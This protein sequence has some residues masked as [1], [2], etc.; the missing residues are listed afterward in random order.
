MNKLLNISL[1]ALAAIVFA[2][3]A[4]EE[5]DL[6][7]SS[8]AERLAA[9]KATYTER[10]AADGGTWVM[11]YFPTSYTY[12]PQGL[13]YLLLMT[14]S[15]DGS[16]RVAMKNDFSDGDYK[17]DTSL[18]EVIADTGP[19]LSFNTY[20]ECLHAF[21]DPSDLSFTTDDETGLGA[22]GDYEFIILNLE[23]G[24]TEATLKGKKRSVYERLRKLPADTDFEAYIE[25][26]EAF[27]D[28]IFSSSAPNYALLTVGDSVKRIDDGYSTIPNIYRL[29]GDAVVNESYHPFIISMQDSIY[30]LRFRDEFEIGE[31]VV[32][33]FTYDADDEMFHEVDNSAYTISGPNPTFFMEGERWNFTRT[34]EMS[35]SLSEIATNMYN[36][37]KTLKYTMSNLRLIMDEDNDS[38]ATFS[39]TYRKTAN[40]TI[41]FLYDLEK[42]DDSFTLT[43]REPV[44]TSSTNPQS[45]VNTIPVI[46]E[47][48]DALS[49]TFVGVAY[50]NPFNLS[51]MKLQ[52]ATNNDKWIVVTNY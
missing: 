28:Y 52:S 37:F 17:E 46:Q 39:I 40:V 8:A 26:V 31:A 43:Y 11:E 16:V 23:E 4:G 42:D 36:D 29:G 50:D 35:D 25:D 14:F 12:E 33:E 6:F 15:D 32:Q 20:N 22:E 21:S 49:D 13:G 51:T 10:L 9:S 24:A 30:T 5:D 45:V 44:V 27:Q 47:M 18:W 19:V 1:F 34:S 7:D 48:V 2:G 38:T 3:C 41:Q